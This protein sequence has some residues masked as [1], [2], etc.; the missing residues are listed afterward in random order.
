MIVTSLG[1][2][3]RH[4]LSVLAR[5][6]AAARVDPVNEG[7]VAVS[8]AQGAVSKGGGSFPIACVE[9]LLRHDL[10]A[11]R[12]GRRGE[13][14]FEITQAGEAH[15]R[16]QAAPA[17]SAFFAQHHEVV[18]STILV[19]GRREKVRLDA[20]EGPLDWLA[21]RKDASGAPLIDVACFTA[22]ER[23][24][25]DLTIALMIPS[26]TTNWDASAVGK[27]SVG[28]RDVAGA[29][30]A[31]LAARQRVDQA[32]NAVGP[33]LAGLLID[34]CGFAKNLATIER[35]RG[36]PSRSGKVVTKLALSRLAD[37]YGLEREARGPARS[38]GIRTWQAALEEGERCG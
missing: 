30:D 33:D 3:A 4:L 20:A 2:R 7:C 8:I 38:R 5:P 24:R 15:A 23:L 25:R 31:T 35:E 26:V 29:S 36:W 37:H 19:E 12:A 18:E 28:P 14:I 16:R 9:E 13:R 21:R 1:R 11:E 6:G 22:G 34:L 10:A 27:T 17:D 32:M